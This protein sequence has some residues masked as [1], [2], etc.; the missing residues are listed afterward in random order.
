[1]LSYDKLVQGIDQASGTMLPALFVVVAERCVRESCFASGSMARAAANIEQRISAE[2]SGSGPH[3]T[4]Q[5][6]PKI[7]GLTCGKCGAQYQLSESAIHRR[8]G[9]NGCD[10]RLHFIGR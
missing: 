2:S 5:T 8:C 7:I 9:L 4:Q 10:G 6:E 1:M 3:S